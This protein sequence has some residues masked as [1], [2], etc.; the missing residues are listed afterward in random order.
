MEENSRKAESSF[1]GNY[2]PF[3]QPEEFI[4]V[5]TEVQEPF[6]AA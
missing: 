3:M 1:L 5:F 4:T 2:Q 6:R